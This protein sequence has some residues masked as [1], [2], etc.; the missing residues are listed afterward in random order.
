[1][2][3]MIIVIAFQKHFGIFLLLGV[4]ELHYPV[5]FEIGWDHVTC[6]G[7]LD[8]GKVIHLISRK[9]L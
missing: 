7:Q 9:A 8:M 2:A 5:H 3:Y 1:M 4:V 6:F